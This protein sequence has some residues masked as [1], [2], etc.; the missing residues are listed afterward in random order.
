[1]IVYTMYGGSAAVIWTDV[2]QMFVYLAG[3]LIVFFALLDGIDGGW[4]AVVA[5]GTRGGQVRASSTSRSTSRRST[6]SGP[7][8]SAASR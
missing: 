1:M 4:G 2:V 3:A 6:R 7:A 5:A 8:S